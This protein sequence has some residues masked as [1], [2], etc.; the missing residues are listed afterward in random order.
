MAPLTQASGNFLH[1]IIIRRATNIISNKFNTQKL[2][3]MISEK[4]VTYLFL[5]PTMIKRLIEE[6]NKKKFDLSSLKRIFYGASPIPAKVL[7]E[8][9]ENFGCI[10]RQHYGM[11]EVPQ[12]VTVFILMNTKYQNLKIKIY[13]YHPVV[14]LALMLTLK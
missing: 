12:P 10:F 2:Q 4:K 3:K 13:V 14:E 7:K 5:V 9:I 11:T 1:P 6:I 8:G